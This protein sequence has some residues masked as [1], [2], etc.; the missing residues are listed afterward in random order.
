MR[1][2]V[3]I[4][5][6]RT[7]FPIHFNAI[8]L[9]DFLA[10]GRHVPRRS[11]IACDVRSGADSLLP[12]SRLSDIDTANTFDISS[13]HAGSA[14]TADDCIFNRAVAYTDDTIDISDDSAGI[15]AAIIDRD[16]CDVYGDIDCP[17][18]IRRLIRGIFIDL[19]RLF[20]SEP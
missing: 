3:I 9:F 20:E 11:C 17:R 13:T 8:A 12:G 15:A 19:S 2:R 14:G 4:S 18:H 7:L 10:R 16:V 1:G 5:P 6:L